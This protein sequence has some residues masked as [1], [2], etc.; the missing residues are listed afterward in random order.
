MLEQNQNTPA[1]ITINLRKTNGKFTEENVQ[2]Y[3]LMMDWETVYPELFGAKLPKEIIFKGFGLGENSTVDFTIQRFRDGKGIGSRSELEKLPQN[4]QRN[5]YKLKYP[6][7]CW[8]DWGG[9]QPPNGSPAKEVITGN[10]RGHTLET[11]FGMENSIVGFYGPNP[12]YTPEQIDDAL[13]ECGGVFNTIHDPAEPISM[14]T[15]KE[16]TS[17]SVR[18][19]ISTKGVAGTP[20]THDAILAKVEKIC[21]EGLFTVNKR[22]RMAQEVINNFNPIHR[23]IPWTKSKTGQYNTS[24][25]MK[26]FNFINTDTVKYHPTSSSTVSQTWRKALKLSAEFPNAE[27]RLVPHTGTL[28]GDDYH[29]TYK[30]RLIKFIAII[31]EFKRNT[32][33]A[34]NSLGPDE[35]G[36]IKTQKPLKDKIVVYAAFP[37]VGEFH[38]I[39]K[40]VF[41]KGDTAFQ[42]LSDNPADYSF[43]LTSDEEFE[44][45]EEENE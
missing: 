15:V 31:N 38:N 8:F 24:E 10:G 21:G 36:I 5:G 22:Q 25:Y 28:E 23:V 19:W 39:D 35:D 1:Y 43:D 32:F 20:N 4:M 6:A 42:R 9:I 29:K 18:R 17:A 27:I 13:E 41:I 2:N 40:P 37:A 3:E 34:F 11:S 30:D 12:D 33:A 26:R 44:L 14:T 7:P 45:D 16:L